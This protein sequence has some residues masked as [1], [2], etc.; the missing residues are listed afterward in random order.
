MKVGD[1]VSFWLSDAGAICLSPRPNDPKATECHGQILF[2]EDQGSRK[3]FMIV[4]QSP[5]ADFLTWGLNETDCRCMIDDVLKNPH[6]QVIDN[7]IDY[8][9]KHVMWIWQERLL[10]RNTSVKIHDP[11]L[12]NLPGACCANPKCKQWFAYAEEGFTCY[13]CRQDRFRCSI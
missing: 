7:F 3:F 9:G 5:A 10:L 6:M 12:P 11:T 1:E 13:S 2:S 8:A 4:N